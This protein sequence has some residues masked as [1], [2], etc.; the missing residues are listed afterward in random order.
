[1]C[2]SRS[3]SITVYKPAIFKEEL[4]VNNLNCNSKIISIFNFWN[5]MSNPARDL[6][7]SEE[8]SCQTT[9][10][11]NAENVSTSQ[12]C[13]LTVMQVSFRA[14]ISGFTMSSNF[15]IRSFPLMKPHLGAD[16]RKCIV[17]TKFHIYS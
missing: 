12:F 9:V 4:R 13:P 10:L 15:T 16:T 1:M 6:K 17:T 7:K 14:I 8:K 2:H 11:E 3:Q 5:Q